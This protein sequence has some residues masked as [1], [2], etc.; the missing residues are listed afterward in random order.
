MENRL[1]LGCA[2]VCNC[3]AKQKQKQKITTC[4]PRQQLSI[5]KKLDEDFFVIM[6]EMLLI[7]WTFT[8]SFGSSCGG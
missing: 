2:G 4:L 1:T 5:S 8:W 3:V 6:K 7:G